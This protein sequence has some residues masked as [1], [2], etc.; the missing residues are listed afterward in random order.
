M[1][2]IGDPMLPEATGP[3]QRRGMDTVEVPIPVGRGTPRSGNGKEDDWEAGSKAE[4][5]K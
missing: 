5:S 4:G 1:M 3:G 2:G